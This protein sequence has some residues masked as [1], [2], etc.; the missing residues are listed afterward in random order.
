MPEA[1]VPFGF[2]IDHVI[3]SK[4]GG[5]TALKN[6]AL[7]CPSCNRYKGP[8]IAGIDPVSGRTVRLFHPR[9]DRWTKHFEW[10]GPRLMSLT[11]IGRATVET[12]RINHPISVATREDLLAEGVFP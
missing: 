8:N 11:R 10:D 1:L 9:R 5:E 4:H 7:A 2:E 3:A 12:L 6:L